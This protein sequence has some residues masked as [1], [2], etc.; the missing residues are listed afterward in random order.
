LSSVIY[1]GFLKLCLHTSEEEINFSH[2]MGNFNTIRCN[3]SFL[4]HKC[5]IY[6]LFFIFNFESKQI[7]HFCTH[8]NELILKLLASY[9]FPIKWEKDRKI[10]PFFSRSSIQQN[11]TNMTQQHIKLISYMRGKHLD[12]Q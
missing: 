7:K 2:L 5:C 4:I 12:N 10:D 8:F 9:L 3:R 11:L 1:V 6:H